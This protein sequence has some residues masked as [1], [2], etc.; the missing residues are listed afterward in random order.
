MKP[1]IDDINKIIYK[2]YKTKHPILVEIILNWSK[3]VGIKYSNN[4]SPFRIS[5]IREKKQKINILLVEVDN[6]STSVEM[7]FQQDVIIERMAVY[8][9]YKAINKI[10]TIVK[11]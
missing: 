8:M 4:T 3:I 2:I 1:I 7:S 11:L 5:T 6:S 10:R 9:G